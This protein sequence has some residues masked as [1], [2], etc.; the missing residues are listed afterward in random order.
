M[1]E[2]YKMVTGMGKY[3]EDSCIKFK[4]K[5]VNHEVNQ[6]GGTGNKFKIFRNMF[7]IIYIFISPSKGNT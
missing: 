3:T 5:F 6:T 7:T 4:F 2:L 1:I